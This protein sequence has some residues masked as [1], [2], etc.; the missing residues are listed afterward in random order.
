MHDGRFLGATMKTIQL[1]LQ[2]KR[3][4][5]L[6]L[7]SRSQSSAGSQG[8]SRPGRRPFEDKKEGEDD[9]NPLGQQYPRDQGRSACHRSARWQNSCRK[10]ATYVSETTRAKRVQNVHTGRNVF[11]LI[12]TSAQTGMSSKMKHTGNAFVV[13]EISRHVWNKSTKFRCHRRTVRWKN[14]PSPQHHLQRRHL[15]V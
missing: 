1:S 12:D 6:P 10:L 7:S 3:H 13:Y 4:F 15:R 8:R 5:V 2:P 11:S 14:A 9:H